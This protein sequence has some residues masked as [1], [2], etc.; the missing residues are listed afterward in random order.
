MTICLYNKSDVCVDILIG[1]SQFFVPREE[2]YVHTCSFDGAPVEIKISVSDVKTDSFDKSAV[3][4]DISTVLLCDFKNS[5]SPAITIR[6]KLKKFQTYTEYR[7]LTIESFN[8]NIYSI[9]HVVNNLDSSKYINSQIKKSKT[10]SILHII[11]N[12]LIDMLL[13]GFLL[14]ALLAWVFSWK[15]ALAVL[16][17]FFSCVNYKFDCIKNLK[18]QV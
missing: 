6:K 13:A 14:S 2:T 15:V 7:Y 11:Q 4:L 18:I 8:L 1:E 17:S 3:S 10:T 16:F 9:K 12:S 5:T